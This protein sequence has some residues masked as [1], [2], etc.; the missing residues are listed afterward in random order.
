MSARA[1]GGMLSMCVLLAGQCMHVWLQQHMCNCREVKGSKP[2]YLHWSASRAA[3]VCGSTRR[4]CAAWQAWVS[5][6][7]L[8]FAGQNA[9]LSMVQEA[10]ARSQKALGACQA[11]AAFRA[12]VAVGT[13]SGATLILMP[14][15]PSVPGQPPSTGVRVLCSAAPAA[16]GHLS[17]SQPA[18]LYACLARTILLHQ[19][20]HSRAAAQHVRACFGDHA[21]CFGVLL[22]AKN[23]MQASDG[24]A[25]PAASPVSL[26]LLPDA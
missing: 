12:A 26:L 7:S 24:S 19:A 22:A 13:A 14:R 11:V 3:I 2:A 21:A 5:G 6:G 8:L 23:D 9:L 18:T 1:N 10:T 15:I 25:S 4:L 20:V 17:S 16:E